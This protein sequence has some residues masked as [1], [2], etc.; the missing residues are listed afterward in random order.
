MKTIT[1]DELWSSIQANEKLTLIE[2][3]SQDEFD[4]GHIAGA[5]RM[6]KDE[7]EAQAPKL[8]TD[9]NARIV[10]YCANLECNASPAVTGKLTSLGYT[11]VSDYKEGKADWIKAGHPVQPSPAIASV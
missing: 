2:A 9:K 6:T 5:I 1:R 11:D 10:V 8:L 4:K 7:V 3:L